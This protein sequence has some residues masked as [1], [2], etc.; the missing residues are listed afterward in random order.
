MAESFREFER[1][2]WEHAAV[3]Y[4]R[5]FADVTCGTISRLLD[6]TETRSGTRLLD[7][8]TGSGI[9][10]R[11]ARERGARPVA[12]DF[13][14]RMAAMASK[15]AE[16][17]LGDVDALPFARESFEVALCN[18]GLLHFAHPERA[19]S[20]IARVLRPGGRAALTV[21]A[22]PEEDPFFA[23][24]YRAIEKHATRKPDVP[25]AAS[26]FHFADEG[27]VSA[28]LSGAGLR[29]AK[30]ERVVWH[31]RVESARSFL[32]LFREGSVRTR[33]ILLA[34]DEV[35]LARIEASVAADLA[36]HRGLVPVSAVLAYAVKP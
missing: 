2:G 23:A 22:P 9:V 26:F 35:T 11:A 6:A 36:P 19:V 30:V 8:A 28:L 34:Q 12:V 17:V 25:P 31:A 13:S 7:V 4:A 18:F 32:D 20:E 16:A 33:A 27:T 3:A 15:V 29:E 21:W 1:R 24:I 14:P 10:A 5:N